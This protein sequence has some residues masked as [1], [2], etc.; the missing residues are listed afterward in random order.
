MKDK[1]EEKVTTGR[2]FTCFDEQN[3]YVSE[4]QILFGI[5]FGTTFSRIAFA[6]LSNEDPKVLVV[7]C[8]PGKASKYSDT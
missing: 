1:I 3:A 4:D 2:L 7:N 6:C 5:D 8:W